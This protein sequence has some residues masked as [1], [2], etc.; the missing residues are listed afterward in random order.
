M[1][2]DIALAIGSFLCFAV[3]FGIGFWL[4]VQFAD[5]WFDGRGR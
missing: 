1:A 5:W 3:A 2:R 4:L